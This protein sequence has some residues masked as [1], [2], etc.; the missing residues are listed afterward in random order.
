MR[1]NTYQVALQGTDA[2]LNVNQ[3]LLP[4]NSA[5]NIATNPVGNLTLI[6]KAHTY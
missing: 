6:N 1:G 4:G 5:K 2:F 3:I